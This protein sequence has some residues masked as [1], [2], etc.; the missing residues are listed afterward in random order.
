MSASARGLFRATG[1][2]AK[3]LA[4]KVGEDLG[5]TYDRAE[6]LPREKDDFY[7]TPPEPT[8]A[9]IHAELER[10]RSFP[11]I[12]EPAA[13]DGAMIR[14][15][16]AAGLRAVGSDKVFRDNGAIDIKDFCD[17]KT[18]P[19][20]AVLTNPPFQE[21][22]WRDGK[23]RWL[24]HALDTLGVDYMAL[25]LNWNWP[26]AGNLGPFW[27]KYAPA[28]VYLMR[29]KVDFT[30]LKQ[31]PAQHGWFVWDKASSGPTQL[32]MLDRKDSRQGEMFEVEP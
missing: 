25:L 14:E 7:Q 21:C 17:F 31:Q 26:A 18:P 4:F 27:E 20:R 12:W 2:S 29:W 10:L 32:L 1:K 19:A 9:I 22:N 6:F 3:P 24:Y 28:R 8:R 11:M 16:E 13:G 5:G 15:I 30:G 23:A